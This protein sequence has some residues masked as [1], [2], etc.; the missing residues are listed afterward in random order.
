MATSDRIA[1]L[2]AKLFAADDRAI[3]LERRRGLKRAVERHGDEPAETLF[4]RIFAEILGRMAVVVDPDDLIVGRTP[5]E[6]PTPDDEPL[7]AWAHEMR[8]APFFRTV[9]HLTVD[10]PTLLDKGMLGIR[11]VA[12]DGLASLD[13]P[14]PEWERAAESAEIERKRRFWGA[15]VD[16]CDAVIGL[17][18]R[19]ASAAARL[20]E[21]E[22]D[23]ARAAD[24]REITGVLR[25][26]PAGPAR[27]FHEAVQSIW[28]LDWIMHTACGARD[29]ALGRLDQYLQP[30]YAADLAAGR[31]T[32][33]RA[34]ELIECLLLKVNEIIGLGDQQTATKR[35]LH[36]DSVVYLI[37]GGQT[38]DGRD[39]TNEVS[40]L[41]LEAADALR[42]KQPT[43]TVRYHAGIDRR[44]WRQLV[45]VMRRGE[46]GIGIYNDGVTIPALVR[47]GVAPDE[48]WDIAFYG[49]CHPS[50][51]GREQPLREYQHNLAKYLE[52][53]LNDGV[54]ML[55]GAVGGARTGDVA[56]FSSFDDLLA[57]LKAQIE[58]GA[59]KAA[60]EC[61]SRWS[62]RNAECLFQF[63]S[64][65]TQG[66]VERAENVSTGA[67]YVHYIHHGG[68][69]ATCADSLAAI[70]GAAFADGVVSLADL[71]DALRANFA[72]HEALRQRL[73]HRYPRFGNDDDAVD[74]LARD[75]SL[76]FCEAILRQ[77]GGAGVAIWPNIYSNHLYMGLGREL[78]APAAGRLAGE[79]V[80]ENQSPTLGRD[81]EGPTALLSSLAKL[82]FDHT[83]AGGV[84]VTFHPSAF[85][86][87]MG[88]DALGHLL[89]TYFAK[90]GLHVQVTVIDRATLLAARERP[91]EHR[92]LVVRVTGYSA[93]FVTLDAQ[94]Q[95]QVIAKAR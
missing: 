95:E 81:R 74:L 10:W 84:T 39:A 28:F 90:G 32:R 54:D 59:A 41:L 24:L 83:P 67:K 80:S 79:P 63:E 26:V 47:C 88:L 72:G 89:E 61:D 17:A 46:N 21:D 30:Y 51:A 53:A 86:G 14:I 94:S 5:E 78:G 76:H 22:P 2:R 18:N 56:A 50:L 92:G 68:A 66:C 29:Y 33:E 52:Y 36:Q 43:L 1:R 9:G 27:T 42:L 44:F 15:T 91:D 13:S 75:V 60:A 71:R 8:D 48:A 31:I 69:I 23:P 62:Q 16:L 37:V 25:R 85:A 57:A 58:F 35:E 6:V 40:F 49:C 7:L 45:D 12:M 4:A 34:L 93:Y 82:P 77:L 3:F 20:A 55:T 19:Y 87:E 65:L 70:R 64:L 38:A 73:K 11:A